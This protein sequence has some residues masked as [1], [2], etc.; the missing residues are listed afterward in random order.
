MLKQSSPISPSPSEF[1]VWWFVLGSALGHLNDGNVW[2]FACMVAQADNPQPL[3]CVRTILLVEIM[4]MGIQV[5]LLT[6]QAQFK[7]DAST[8]V[9][10]DL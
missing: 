10:V 1:L 5:T 8:K 7:L 2:D 3:I 6:R 4:T 9:Y